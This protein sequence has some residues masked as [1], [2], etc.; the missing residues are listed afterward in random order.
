MRSLRK[1]L[2][3]LGFKEN[4]TSGDCLDNWIRILIA[5]GFN[6]LFEYSLRGLNDLA[7]RPFLPIFLFLVY[8]PYFTLLEYSIEKYHFRD[9][10]VLVA[11]FVFGSFAAFFIPGPMF[12]GNLL[13]GLNWGSFFFITVIW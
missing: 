1:Q 6:L 9:W 11:G 3:K 5:T 10:Q 4:P 2:R 7:F 12:T 13:L 8:F